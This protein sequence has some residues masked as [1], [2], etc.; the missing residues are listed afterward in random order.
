MRSMPKS[1]FDFLKTHE[2]ILLQLA[3]LAERT[4]VPD[5]NTTLIKLRQLGEAFAKD[6]FVL[7]AD[8]YSAS[9]DWLSNLLDK[10]LLD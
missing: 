5:P 8:E 10:N 7:N 3:E 9:K 1:N 2:P 6:K 4:F